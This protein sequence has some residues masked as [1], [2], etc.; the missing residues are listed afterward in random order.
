MTLQFEIPHGPVPCARR[1]DICAVELPTALAA[2]QQQ[3]NRAIDGGWTQVG[4]RAP[5]GETGEQRQRVA[6]PG[7]A[8]AARSSLRLNADAWNVRLEWKTLGGAAR[9]CGSSRGR[10]VAAELADVRLPKWWHLF[11]RGLRM[12][13]SDRLQHSRVWV[14]WRHMR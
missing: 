4:C 12:P 8:A 11:G 3:S 2:R 13:T 14:D 10:T 1:S 6:Q 7:S 5:Q 9:R